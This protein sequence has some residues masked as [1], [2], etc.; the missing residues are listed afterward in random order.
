MTAV[1]PIKPQDSRGRIA[2]K[3]RPI[4][5]QATQLILRVCQ[6][7]GSASFVDDARQSLE[8][9]GVAA[10]IRDRNTAVLFD[11]LVAALSYQ[12]IADQIASDYMERY[13]LATWH[14]IESDLRRRPSCPK[15]RSYWHFPDCPYNKTR[16]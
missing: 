11:W 6:I 14:A 15:L 5:D 12:G 8:A 3:D 16:Y 9:E 10:A 4:V 7:A 13:G 2:E 1:D